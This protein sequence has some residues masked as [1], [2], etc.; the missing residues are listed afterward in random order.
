MVT[1]NKKF[2]DGT[3][4]YIKSVLIQDKTAN[5]NMIP[6]YL[7][8]SEAAPSYVVLMYIY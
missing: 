4:D 8:I 3:L 2:M 7:G 1:T 5:P 6:Y